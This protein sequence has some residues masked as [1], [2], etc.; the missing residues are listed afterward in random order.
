MY[1]QLQSDNVSYEFINRQINGMIKQLRGND[2]GMPQRILTASSLDN[3]WRKVTRLI[4]VSQTNAKCPNCSA[5]L[6]YHDNCKY[7][8]EP[9]WSDVLE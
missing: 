8:G 6:S 2:K 5:Q 7:C 9:V 3:W 1:P 4:I